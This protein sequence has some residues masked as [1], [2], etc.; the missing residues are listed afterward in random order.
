[1]ANINDAQP[2]LDLTQTTTIANG[3]AL[4]AAIDVAGC[5]IQGVLLPA[6]WTAAVMTFAVSFDGITYFPLFDSSGAEVSYT[7]VAGHA[8]FFPTYNWR[9]V[10]YLKI[11]S[12][13]S[14]SPVNQ[15][16]TT[17]VTLALRLGA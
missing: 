17:I 7:V 16:Q 6:V 3:A 8:V 1:M 15:G 10:R 2:C 11:R 5:S 13:T 12:G 14:A 9:M 4:S